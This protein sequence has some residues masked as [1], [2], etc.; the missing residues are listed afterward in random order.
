MKFES[1]KELY[2]SRVIYID[3]I[4]MLTDYYAPRA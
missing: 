2:P 3:L 1:G 4:K